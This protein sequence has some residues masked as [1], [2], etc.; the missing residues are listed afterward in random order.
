MHWEHCA[1]LGTHL[2]HCAHKFTIVKLHFL[3]ERLE[4]LKK[5]C[6]QKASHREAMVKDASIPDQKNTRGLN[7]FSIFPTVYPKNAI[8]DCEFVR[9]VCRMCA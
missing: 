6:V 9:T 4:I 2:A 8:Y 1:P 7:T 5:D 3:A